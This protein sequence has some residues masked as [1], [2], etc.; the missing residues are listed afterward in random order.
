MCTS[1]TRTCSESLPKDGTEKGA[2]VATVNAA[3]ALQ[4]LSSSQ[5]SLCVGI[6]P[7]RRAESNK[8]S[9]CPE[10]DPFLGSLRQEVTC[11]AA[12]SPGLG[13]RALNKSFPDGKCVSLEPVPTAAMSLLDRS[14]YWTLVQFLF[15][16]SELQPSQEDID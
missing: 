7:H 8:D 10:S 16:K 6:Q 3:S 1:I 12:Q 2:N 15:H 13:L 14:S 11:E 9:A 5:C 4:D